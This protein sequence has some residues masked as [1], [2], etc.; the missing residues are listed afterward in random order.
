VEAGSVNVGSGRP[1]TVAAVAARIAEVF[2]RPDLVKLGAR[3]Y[4]A[5]DPMFICAKIERLKATGWRPKLTLERGITE[6]VE[7]WMAR[8]RAAA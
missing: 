7:W 5:R 1:I 8:G 3:P 2:G 4:A 6:T